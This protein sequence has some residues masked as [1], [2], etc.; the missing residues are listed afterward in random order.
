VLNVGTSD[1]FD[2]FGSAEVGKDSFRLPFVLLVGVEARMGDV[3]TFVVVVFVVI[4][5]TSVPLTVFVSNMFAR[6]I[7]GLRGW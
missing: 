6:E 7:S 2:N 4:A 5:S 1:R 3:S